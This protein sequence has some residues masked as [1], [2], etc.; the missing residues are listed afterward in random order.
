MSPNAIKSP[1]S[2]NIHVDEYGVRYDSTIESVTL[3]K[4]VSI[5]SGIKYLQNLFNEGEKVVVIKDEIKG[6]VTESILAFSR[7]LK[8]TYGYVDQKPTPTFF[9]QRPPEQIPVTME[10]GSVIYVPYGRMGLPD[11]DGGH[12][13]VTVNGRR[14]GQ[15]SVVLGAT[16]QRKHEAKV[17]KLFALAK[18]LA[19]DESIYAGTAFKLRFKDEDGEDLPF[20]IPVFLDL[21]KV[22]ENQLVFS[23]EVGASINTSIFTPIE[24]TDVCRAHKVPLKRGV[25]LAG[26]YGTGKTLTTFVTAKKAVANGWTFVYCESA[27]DLEIVIKLAHSY[28]PAVV[29][30]EDIDR[31]VTGER[32][33]AMDGLLNI[34]DGIESKGT[35][36]MVIMTTNHVENINRALLRPGRL[37]AVINVLPPDAHAVERLIRKYAGK[38]LPASE[39]LRLV[40]D[41][42]AG[43][44]PAV[45]R[46]VVER[47]KLTSIMR[48]GNAPMSLTAGDLE[49]SAST[50]HNQLE[51]LN[52][53]AIAPSSAEETLKALSKLMSSDVHASLSKLSDRMDGMSADII[54]AV[55]SR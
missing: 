4:D 21:S 45:I 12:V 24:H 26:K 38:L 27:D 47:A 13:D 7:A 10:D 41:T 6:F 25:L 15:S 5:A 48:L 29:F 19:K 32:S 43:Y 42:M 50:M 17:R 53:E 31:V 1:E 3:P 35:E 51:L 16:I 52:R 22:D 40:S 18:K 20:P 55:E 49:V 44:I 36:L 54:E 37:D 2:T 30:C 14:N 46:E 39:C 34:I 23:D 33:L 28:M 9:G 11:I 8:V